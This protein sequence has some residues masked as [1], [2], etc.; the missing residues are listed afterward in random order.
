MSR[1]LRRHS[2]AEVLLN[3][4]TG[5]IISYT[6]GLFIFPLIFHHSVSAGQN[7]WV[8]FIYTVISIARSYI[9]RRVFN[10]WQHRSFT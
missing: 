5:F 7:F 3:T 2:V 4:A 10:W 6:A 9:W 8:V 1:Q